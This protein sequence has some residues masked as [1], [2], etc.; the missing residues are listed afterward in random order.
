MKNVYCVKLINAEGCKFD[1]T[2]SVSTLKS[3]KEWASGRTGNYNV[4]IQKNPNYQGYAEKTYQ[5]SIKG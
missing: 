2:E 1:E 4:I 3:A 5:Y